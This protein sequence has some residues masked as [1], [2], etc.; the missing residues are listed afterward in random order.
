M[1]D[2]TDLHV[3]LVIETRLLNDTMRDDLRAAARAA[4]EAAADV[5]ADSDF[6]GR[7]A[8]VD[9]R[10]ARGVRTVPQSTPADRRNVVTSG[11]FPVAAGEDAELRGPAGPAG[12]R[13]PR[14]P[15]GE[16]GEPGEDGV[17]ADLDRNEDG[18]VDFEDFVSRDAEGRFNGSDDEG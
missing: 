18:V 9:F 5:L 7:S 11:P 4:A 10:V 8:S 1:P 16:R 2:V 13:G 14:G 6:H 3:S 12:P 17:D 15:E